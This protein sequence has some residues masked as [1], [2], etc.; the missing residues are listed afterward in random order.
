MDK[1]APRLDSED[2]A[3]WGGPK[4]EQLREG[5]HY[6]TEPSCVAVEAF[7]DAVDR[8]HAESQAMITQFRGVDPMELAEGT[9]DAALDDIV[10]VAVHARFRA[11]VLA[12]G[13]A[14]G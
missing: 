10:D 11:L 14:R 2:L 3:A 1:P 13:F 4:D 9:I 7:S 12:R 6:L 8:C 5:L